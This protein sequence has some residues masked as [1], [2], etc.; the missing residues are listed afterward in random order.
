MKGLKTKLMSAVAMLT[1]S[2][3]MLVS[4][5]FAWYTLS[6]NPEV[7]GITATAVANENLEIALVKELDTNG[8]PKPASAINDL[9]V[10]NGGS[11]GSTK[12]N[13]YT[14]GNLVNLENI[15]VDTE[16]RPSTPTYTGEGATKKISGGLKAPIYGEDGR[17]KELVALQDETAYKTATTSGEGE[18]QTTQ[19]H[20]GWVN[21]MGANGLGANTK[22]AFRV[23]Y[24]LRTNVGGKITLTSATNR[25]A[26][27]DPASS[28]TGQGST[29]SM[30]NQKH[31]SVKAIFKV[32]KATDTN[33]SAWSTAEG[34]IN[35]V[36]ATNSAI[37]GDDTH[38]KLDATIVEN[39]AENTAYLV[40]MYVYLNGQVVTNADVKDDITAL[41]VNVQFDNASTSFTDDAMQK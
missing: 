5:S 31:D 27:N 29:I 16:L 3:V 7:K 39:A 26:V 38:E 1:I 20:A 22:Y 14:W 33:G 19:E 28:T 24:V 34:D 4:T 6:T 13:Y 17:A 40:Q 15:L 35:W 9:S 11:Q 37:T 18:S 23:D 8:S 12:D 25:D 32:T 2:A 41:A 36:E 21:V 10:F 30:V